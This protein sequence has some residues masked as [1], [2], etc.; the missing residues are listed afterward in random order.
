MS[1][2]VPQLIP[3]VGKEELENLKE[4]IKKQWITEGPFAKEFLHLI[5]EKTGA[6]YAVL[7]NNGTLA[8]FMALKSI[9]IKE[10]D[11]VIIFNHQDMLNNIAEA[12]E[13]IVYETLTSISPRVKKVLKS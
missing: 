12:S 10:G 3:F 7:A 9:G 5:K 8:L 11:E 2:K 6:K 4:V 13:T 1:Y